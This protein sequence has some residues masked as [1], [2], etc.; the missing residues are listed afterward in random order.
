MGK[1]AAGTLTQPRRVI[2]SFLLFFFICNCADGNRRKSTPPAGHLTP[3]YAHID[4]LWTGARHFTD[5][6]PP[7]ATPGPLQPGRFGTV[8]ELHELDATPSPE[9]LEFGLSLH[10][11]TTATGEN[12]MLAQAM[13]GMWDVGAE[14]PYHLRPLHQYGEA[15]VREVDQKPAAMGQYI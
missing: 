6:A 14:S 2:H 9:P 12:S 10:R 8:V 7:L 4:T 11:P 3:Q 1:L 15:I 13:V 5:K